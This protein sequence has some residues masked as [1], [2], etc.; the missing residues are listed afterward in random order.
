[1]GFLFLVSLIVSAG[2]LAASKFLSPM[3]LPGG[4]SLW[5]AIDVLVSLAFITVL[6]AVLFKT[7]PD[8]KLGWRGVWIGA[9]VNARL[10]TVG[11]FL[12]GLYLTHT[13]TASAF[14]AAGSLVILL[15]WVYYSSQIVL[16]GAELT[17]QFLQQ[18]GRQIAPR[19]NAILVGSDTRPDC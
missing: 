13:S 12:I 18:S 2:L 11:K 19:D 17:R 3:A 5:Q 6:L 16:F 8:V 10:F 14:G 7:L 9:R 4:I 1:I 15:L